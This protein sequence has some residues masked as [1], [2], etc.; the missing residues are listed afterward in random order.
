M[1]ASRPACSTFSTI[2]APWLAALADAGYAEGID[3]DLASGGK[4]AS[5]SASLDEL[6]RGGVIGKESRWL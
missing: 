4:I 1:P 3:Y 5:Y 2:R 6:M